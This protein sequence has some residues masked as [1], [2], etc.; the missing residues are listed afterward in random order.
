MRGWVPNRTTPFD[1]ITK[2]GEDDTKLR[3][4]LLAH[5]TDNW[6]EV[7]MC[8]E[9]HMSSCDVDDEAKTTFR[10]ALDAHEHGRYRC[11]S[12]SLFPEFERV[13]REALF[14]GQAGQI[15]YRKFV[16]KLTGEDG[17]PNLA[18]VLFAGIQDMVLF[19]YLTEGVRFTG[20]LDDQSRCAAPKYKPGLAVGVNEE[21]IEQARH[22]PI[23][24]RH[25]VAHGLVVYSSQQSSLNATFIADY[26]FSI[27][28]R[29]LRNRSGVDTDNCHAQ[30]DP[31]GL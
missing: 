28:S 31:D 26:V 22:S 8:L 17:N 15:S 29:F 7:R 1:L 13:F 10:E 18:D 11:V 5:Y 3:T 4:L 16:K 27:V 2:C 12:R 21:N 20:A 30:A 14:E 24:T 25:A 23:P 9:S 6:P 19:K